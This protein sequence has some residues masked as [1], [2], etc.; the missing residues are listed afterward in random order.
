MS[1]RNLG[2]GNRFITGPAL[3]QQQQPF[4]FR[5]EMEAHTHRQ[6]FGRKGPGDRKPGDRHRAA[7]MILGIIVGSIAGG[8][9][10]SRLF[11]FLGLVLGLVVGAIIGVVVG[12]RLGYAIW[13]RQNPWESPPPPSDDSPLIK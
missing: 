13:K 12:S 8:I 7:G 9:F 4:M 2:Q 5:P 11:G 6:R 3:F 1:T 10:G